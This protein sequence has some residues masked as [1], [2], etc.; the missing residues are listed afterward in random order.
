MALKRKWD[1]EVEKG[2]QELTREKLHSRGRSRQWAQTC[3]SNNGLAWPN[4]PSLPYLRMALFLNQTVK[5]GRAASL[6][7]TKQPHLPARKRLH[8]VDEFSPCIYQR[9]GVGGNFLHS[10]YCGRSFTH[11]SFCVWGMDSGLEFILFQLNVKGAPPSGGRTVP[12]HST[13]AKPGWK[14]E[15][16]SVCVWVCVLSLPFWKPQHS[17]WRWWTCAAVTFCQSPSSCVRACGVVFFAFH[18]VIS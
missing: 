1:K 16:P 7:A 10:N 11:F 18:T 2:S 13:L 8:P 14:A 3:Q 6:L 15:K 4:L 17:W 9:R 5:L 12:R